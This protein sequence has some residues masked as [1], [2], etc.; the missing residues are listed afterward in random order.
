MRGCSHWGP[1]VADPGAVLRIC[2]SPV[3]S[4]ETVT[5]LSRNEF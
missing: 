3:G 2:L 1:G 5:G 4:G